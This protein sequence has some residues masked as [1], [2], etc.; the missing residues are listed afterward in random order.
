L[1]GGKRAGASPPGPFPGRGVSFIRATRN[2]RMP[3]AICSIAATI[4]SVL[5]WA[6]T[7]GPFLKLNGRSACATLLNRIENWLAGGTI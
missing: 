5:H 3:E 6:G 1:E 7:L 2:A 4:P